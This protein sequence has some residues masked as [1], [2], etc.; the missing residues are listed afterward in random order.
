MGQGQGRQGG[1]FCAASEAL[2][3]G[4]PNPDAVPQVAL[5]GGNGAHAVQRAALVVVEQIM[6]NFLPCRCAARACSS[7]G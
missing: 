4:E 1:A 5:G 7:G 2:C 3:R 6:D